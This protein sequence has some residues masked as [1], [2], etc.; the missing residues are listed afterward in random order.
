MAWLVTILYRVPAIAV[1]VRVYCDF[2]IR[3]IRA[4]MAELHKNIRLDKIAA[5]IR[6]L[7]RAIVC[8]KARH[9]T[10]LQTSACWMTGSTGYLILF[11]P[12]A[13]WTQLSLERRC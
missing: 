13:G 5:H 2:R 8:P 12:R 10:V 11:E 9:H 7:Y 3:P 6:S 1:L 4:E